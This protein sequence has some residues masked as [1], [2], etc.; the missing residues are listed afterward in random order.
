ME[1]IILTGKVRKDGG[2]GVCRQL[3]RDGRLPGVLYGGDLNIPVSIDLKTFKHLLSS[4]VG[5]N[6]IFQFDLE[7]EDKK[8]RWVLI[9]E[10]Q[11]HPAS[12]DLLH[13]DLYEVS[14]GKEIVVHVPVVLAGEP[15]GSQ[16]GGMLHHHLKE[17]SLECLPALIPGHVVVDVSGLHIG[18]AIH[19]KDLKLDKG[20]KVLTDTG[21]IVVS[22]IGLAKEEVPTAQAPLEQPPAS[23][24]GER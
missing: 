18:D 8:E 13:V 10:L 16:E 22:I 23:E 17:L 2:K 4:G 3:R 5:G 7:R 19:V 14:M 9:R 15:V 1:T 6:T 12:R 20:I 11:I 24:E 21:E